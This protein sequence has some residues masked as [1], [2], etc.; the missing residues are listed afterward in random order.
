M[1][2]WQLT[3]KE[4]YQEYTATVCGKKFVAQLSYQ[5]DDA[6]QYLDEFVAR[7]QKLYGES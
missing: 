5:A 2:E 1:V 3:N 4:N 6:Q 7:M